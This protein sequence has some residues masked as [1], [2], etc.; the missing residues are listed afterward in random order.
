MVIPHYGGRHA[1]PAFHNPQLQRNIE[2]VSDHRRSEDWA[3]KFLENGW[4]LGIIGSTDQHA[5][6]AGFG[7]RRAGTKGG[8][9]GEV[10]EPASPA[11]NGTALVAVYAPQLTREGI[12]QG[13]YHRRTYATTGTRIVLDFAINNAPM[14]SE[15]RTTT[16][17][18]ITAS[19]EGTA[20][21]K[22]LR[23]VKNGKVVYS[24]SPGGLSASLTFQDGS[25]DYEGKYY[26][27]DLV[28]DD[29]KKAI[30]S[31]IWVN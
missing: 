4:R 22:L 1:N 30:S 9:P 2:I 12:F 27:I 15:I 26:Y 24:V 16:A 23:V 29:G 19:A 21:I 3:S 13:L 17:P 20:P 18:K 11:E 25:G 14:G 6:N 28:Q 5:G 8:E 7:V 10:F 31:P